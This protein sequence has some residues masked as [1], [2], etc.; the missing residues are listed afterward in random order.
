MLRSDSGGTWT[1]ITLK[2]KDHESRQPI[3]HDHAAFLIA[4]ALRPSVDR[5]RLDCRDELS[6]PAI[7]VPGTTSAAS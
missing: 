6:R 1:K 4:S 7:P 5:E 2:E 3:T